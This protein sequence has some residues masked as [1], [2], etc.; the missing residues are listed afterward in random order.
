MHAHTSAISW[1][2]RA[3]ARTVLNIARENGID[4]LVLCNHYQELYVKNGDADALAQSYVQEY[5]HTKELAD[6][7]GM[8]LFFGVEVTAKLHDN[9]HILLYGLQPDFA[10]RHPAMYEYPLAKLSSLV[11]AEGGLIVQAHPF[12]SG[13]H[14]QELSLLDGVEV[15]CH[16][17][18]EG[19]HCAELMEIAHEAGLIVTCGG[20]YHADTH[21]AICGAHFPDEVRTG[22]AL[23]S[24]LKQ[25]E[26][27]TLHVHEVGAADHQ[28]VAFCRQ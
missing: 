17:L 16:P 23:V 7:M 5:L 8:P 4:G 26:Q 28:D 13:G 18:Y 14:L 20:D 10:L 11:H 12:R 27:I 1:C 25:A 24:Y 6:A 19:T 3:D 9:A 21:R 22:A 15:N 2:C